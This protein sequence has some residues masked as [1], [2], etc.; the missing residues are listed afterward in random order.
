MMDEEGIWSAKKQARIEFEKHRK[1][2]LLSEIC[3]QESED[4]TMSM[5]AEHESLIRTQ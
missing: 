5:R 1:C 3:S 4:E 2:K